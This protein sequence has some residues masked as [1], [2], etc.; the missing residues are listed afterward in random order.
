MDNKLDQPFRLDDLI[1]SYVLYD[2]NDNDDI[3]NDE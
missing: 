2:C 1:E 3:D